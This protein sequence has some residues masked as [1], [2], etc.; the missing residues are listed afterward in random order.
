MKPTIVN[1]R[2]RLNERVG[3]GGMAMVYRGEDLLL[4]RP[5]AV[6]FLREPYTSDPEFRQRFLDEARAAA[7]LDH[8]NI[9]RIY[10][11]GKDE[12]DHPYIVM[13][14]VE[15]EDLKIM[16]R[17]DGP[18]SVTRALNLVEQICAGVGHAHR[19]GIV[20]CDLKPQNI[21][22]THEGKVKVADFGIAR[23]MQQEG[24]VVEE[25]PAEV[26]WGSPHYISPEQASGTSPT[27]ASDVYSIGV[28][29]YEMLTGVPPFHDP[30]PDVLVMK[31]LRE[32]PVPLRSLNPRVPPGLEHLVHKVLAKE[33]A[34]RF[35]N[36]EH[37]G[38]AVRQ[39]LDE[40]AGRTRPQAPVAE[41]PALA[42]TRDI[43]PEPQREDTQPVPRPQDVD[44][45]LWTLIGVAAIA[46]L[47]LV[48]LWIFVVQAYTQ[49]PTLPT[50]IIATSTPTAPAQEQNVSVPN[51]IG[52]NAAD[53]QRLA[54]G[55]GLAIEVIGEEEV[56]DR[57]PGAVL[58]QAPNP[59]SRVPAGT[60]LSVIVAAGR[61]L[62]LQDV[63]GFNLHDENV[64]VQA[65]L[66]DDGLLVEVEE[67]WSTEPQ[68]LILEQTP[69]SGT[70]I[71]AGSTITLT[72]SGG[73][74]HPIPLNVN[75][76][77]QVILEEARV[78]QLSYQPG[79]IVPVTL[80]WRCLAPIDHAYKV[81]VHLLT[82][83]FQLLAQRDVEPANGLRPTHVWQVGEIINDPHQIALPEDAAP[84]TYQIRVGLYDENG[85]MP[86]V[87]PGET[88][89]VD[90]TIFIT[91]IEIRP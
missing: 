50:P 83:D 57:R 60:T 33:P 23:A 12:G 47:G 53:A 7:R 58:E 30:D 51:L 48:P 17:R 38:L 80:R 55:M 61:Q 78:T 79:D 1:E 16:I 63:V 88:Q 13:E 43:P 71:Q 21:L 46:V 26:V 56:T 9:V 29:L 91:N 39:Y 8:P 77:D 24:P 27:P 19:A 36:A 40:G 74:N 62:V 72:V 22:V 4:E 54:E 84:G 37:F 32:T 18:F 86:I 5:V 75:L 28:I 2:Y 11:V 70:E 82:Q 25:E 59:G 87:D 67:I 35:R 31:H 76:N 6:K 20:H 64:N 69:P 65:R 3:A 68:G 44:Y 66:E 41:A 10:D 14:L 15:G 73:I 89:V 49:S 81:F 45:L 34:Q 90:D 42:P 85:R 52:L